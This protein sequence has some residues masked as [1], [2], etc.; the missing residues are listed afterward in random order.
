MHQH[1]LDLHRPHNR[2]ATGYLSQFQFPIARGLN[3]HLNSE[4]DWAL[5]SISRISITMTLKKSTKTDS[6][7]KQSSA[8]QKPASGAVKRK[9]KSPLKKSTKPKTNPVTKKAAKE[10]K[11]PSIL[12][13]GDTSPGSPGTSGPGDRYVVAPGATKDPIRPSAE[14]PKEE[15]PDAYGTKR[16]LLTARDPHWLYAHWDLTID[17]QRKYNNLSKRRH[18]TVR[19]YKD[20]R[21]ADPSVEVNVHPESR[22][23]FIHV[24]EAGAKFSAVLGYYDRQGK[25][26]VVSKSEATMTPPDTLSSD[27][28]FRWETLPADL[29]LQKLVALV[30]SAVRENMPLLE[31]IQTLRESGHPGL[32]SKR[33]LATGQWTDDQ[34]RALSELISMDEVRRVWVG[35]LEITEL[36]RRQL[37]KQVS[38]E[39]A[40]QFSLP[41]SWSG[42]VS[43]FSSPTGGMPG[44]KSFWFNV[45]AELIIYGATEPDAAVRI[46]GRKIKLRPDG[47]FSFRFSLPDGRYDL[48][49]IAVS[50][51]ETDSRVANLHFSRETEYRGDV[52]A[53]PQ[54]PG[55]KPPQAD[56]VA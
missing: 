11:I 50:A 39:G 48:P 29:Q 21:T 32:P 56:S 9:A 52:G 19:V 5:N 12:L 2:L 7:T 47:S 54:D 43:S 14:E 35:S 45:N 24:G 36:V 23:W 37:H 40:A 53:H 30:R 46:A 31:A 1:L 55:L 51:D 3:L 28:T 38:S 33:A 34:Q 15:L 26:V 8:R 42:G 13:E 25:W 22:N 49:A 18:L 6:Q 17:Q 41:S 20:G 16:L 27:T 10:P 4:A 44:R